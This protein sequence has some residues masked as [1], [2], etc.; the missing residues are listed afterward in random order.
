MDNTN[1]ILLEKR[2]K[3]EVS[4]QERYNRG[5]IYCIILKK[6]YREIL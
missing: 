3:Q 4:I 2:N 6:R 1:C 5:S